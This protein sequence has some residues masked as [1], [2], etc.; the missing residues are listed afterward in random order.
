MRP[1]L[2]LSIFFF[3]FFFFFF[4][5]DTATTEI[6][7]LSLHDAL[8]ISSR[9]WA[10]SPPGARCREPALRSPVAAGGCSGAPL[11]VGPDVLALAPAPARPPRAARGRARGPPARAPARPAGAARARRPRDGRARPRRAR[12]RGAAVGLRHG[13]RADRGDRR[14][15]RDGRLALDARR[16][17]AAES[18]RAPEAGG[19]PP[20]RGVARRPRGAPRVRGEELHPVAAHGRRRRHRALPRQPRSV[21]RGRGRH[22][23][24][25][26]DR[27]GRGPPPRGARGGGARARDPERRR[28]V[29]RPP[30]VA[31]G[32]ARGA[33][34]G[35][36]GDH[37]RVRHGG[38]RDHPAAR[39]PGHR[40]QARRRR[41]DRDHP[42][43]SRPAPR[44]R[45]CGRWGVHRRGGLRQGLTHPPGARAPRSAAAR[46][47]RRALAAAPGGV[48]PPA[49]DAAAPSRRVARRRRLVRPP[50]RAPAAGRGRVRPRGAPRCRAGA[51]PARRDGVVQ[52][53]EPPAGGAH[54][55]WRDRHRG[56]ATRD[57]LQLR[58]GDARGRLARRGR[59]GSRARGPESRSA[60]AAARALQSRPRPSAPGPAR[61]RRRPAIARGCHRGVPGAPAATPRR[62]RRGVELRA[63]APAPATATRRQPRRPGEPAAVAAARAA[64]GGGGA[65]DVAPAGGTAPLVRRARR[66]GDP[67]PAPAGHAAGTSERSEGLV[68]LLAAL[69]LL[70]AA[71]Q[72]PLPDVVTRSRLDRSRGVDF[73]ARIAPETVFVG[74]QAT[75][76]L[77]VFLDQD[78]RQRLRR[79]PEF[80]PPESR[81]MLAYDLPERGGALQVT[82]DGRPYEVHIFRRALFPLTRGRYDIPQARLTYALPQ[83]PSFFSREES[84]TLRSEAVALVAVD[85]P[86]AG[87]PADWAGAI[88]V[89]RATARAD[90]TRARAGDPLVLTLRL[91]GQGNATLLP[92][93]ALAVPW[94][95]VVAAD[96][97]ARLDSSLTMLRGAKEF[98]WLLAPR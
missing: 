4:F 61:R 53:R 79:N 29:R 68:T 90:A 80:L 73:H 57:P 33:R 86:A 30:G 52:G 92:R 76:Q 98:D 25:A 24:R 36:L 9:S 19:A 44:R 7:T 27:P 12:L 58:H 6:Y 41:P 66:E 81:A 74:Q 84:Y 78:T 89:W 65:A 3:F 83:S 43:R 50:P 26:D 10:S 47:R 87:R 2:H 71:A 35:D 94:A 16:G 51:I 62:R 96:E 31:R 14:G 67:G 34:R 72:A 1:S 95:S 22:G 97:R 56:P 93:P 21:H 45:P 82:L 46:S 8:P 28:G 37:G 85:P 23:A 18:P 15:A 55:A 13:D 17:R 54:L 42:L 5:N 20:P 63:R 75:Y 49:G 11:P 77:G 88:G 48:V 38:R 32:R 69:F 40:R 60:R 59:G 39:R 64:S 70:Q 91:E